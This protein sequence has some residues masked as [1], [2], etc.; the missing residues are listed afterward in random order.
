MVLCSGST[1]SVQGEKFNLRNMGR[2][3]GELPR[4]DARIERK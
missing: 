4:L 1:D 3:E 2:V